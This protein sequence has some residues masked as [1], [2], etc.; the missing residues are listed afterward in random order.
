MPYPICRHIKT[1][2]L[3]CQ[4]P[5]LIGH[6]LCYFHTRQATRHRNYRP[7]QDLDPFFEP[8]RHIRL[9]IIEDRDSL[10]TALSQT[11]NA[12]A[13]GQIELKH[14]KAIL[15]GL[16]L[17]SQAIQQQE[18]QQK[19]N[20]ELAPSPGTVVQ[21]IVYSEDYLDLAPPDPD[22]TAKLEQLK[23]LDA[24]FQSA[25]A[26]SISDAASIELTDA[27]QEP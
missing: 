10:L 12:M 1:N 14:G 21:H 13:T 16:S 25:P 2:G 20:P 23:T 22:N 27:E 6:R 17:A 8:G 4:S 15:Y 18:V 26:V 5:A 24:Q 11:V 9:N 3:Q 7:N 19:D